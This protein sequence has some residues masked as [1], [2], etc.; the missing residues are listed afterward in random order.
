MPLTCDGA[1]RLLEESLLEYKH[2][3]SLAQVMIA[4]KGVV[5]ENR[6]W[7]QEQLTKIY[8][9]RWPEDVVLAYKMSSISDLDH[10]EKGTT[11]TRT[12]IQRS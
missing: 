3:R 1:R 8:G 2:V 6:R 12:S 7:L 11:T 10:G 9:P 4:V 5:P